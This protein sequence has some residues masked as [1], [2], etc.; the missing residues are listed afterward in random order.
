MQMNAI[1]WG[2]IIGGVVKGATDYN[3]AKQQVKALEAQNDALAMQYYAPNP[4]YT[5]GGVQYQPPP[6]YSYSGYQSLPQLPAPGIDQT[7]MLYIGG[8]ALL[9]ILLLKRK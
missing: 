8:A 1:D 6:Q 4:G 3:L 2:G 7:T 5:T 9:L